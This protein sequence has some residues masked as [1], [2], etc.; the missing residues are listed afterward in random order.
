MTLLP[1]SGMSAAG[2]AAARGTCG[3]R[4]GQP[5]G[6]GSLR[7]GVAGPEPKLQGMVTR[8]GHSLLETS[9]HPAFGD[10]SSDSATAGSRATCGTLLGGRW[11]QAIAPFYNK[12]LAA[13]KVV[14]S[15]RDAAAWSRTM[16][17][18]WQASLDHEPVHKKFRKGPL[19]PRPSIF[20]TQRKHLLFCQHQEPDG[21][22]GLEALLGLSLSV[23]R[24][25]FILLTTR[26][27]GA[28]AHADA[29]T[30]HSI[31][32][33]DPTIACPTDHWDEPVLGLRRAISPFCWHPPQKTSTSR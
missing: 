27:R 31:S 3:Q 18:R 10:N 4:P 25:M 8:M 19:G 26:I 2:P 33:G 1:R 28:A 6:A 29:P 30:V 12:T 32:Q 11:D 24:L 23:W 16:V 20:S 15:L 5:H 17:S 9:Q 14:G 7:S 13:R 21:A 22:M